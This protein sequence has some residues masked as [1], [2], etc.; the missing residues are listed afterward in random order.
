MARQKFWPVA[1]LIL[2]PALGCQGSIVGEGSHRSGPGKTTTPGEPDPD[3]TKD[4]TTDPTKDPAKTDPTKPIPDGTVITPETP[5]DPLAA[6]PSPLRRLTRREY[7]NTVRDLL[8]DTTH[9][10]DGFPVDHDDGFLF[11]RAGLVTAQDLSTMRDA[12]EALAA[13]AEKNVTMLAP[14]TGGV[15]EDACA[16]TFVNSFGLR[17]YRRP[18][19]RE[20]SDRLIALYRNARTSLGLT[21][22]GGIGLLVEAMLQSP[23][24]L[25]H[26]ENGSAPLAMDGNV[27]RLGPYENAARL[28]YFLWGSMPDAALF[29]A[30]AGNHLGT[31]AELEAQ[32][33]R[34]LADA[35]ARDTVAA[36]VNDW[37]NLDQVTDRPKDPGTYPGFTDPLKSAMIDESRAF[38]NSVVLDGDSRLTTLLTATN[39]YVNQPLASV[40][41]MKGVQGADLKPMMLDPAQRSGLL[42][43]A[44][45]LTVTGSTNGSH[46]V[47]RGHKVYQRVLCRELPPPPPTVPPAKPPS[48]GGTTRERFAEHGAMKCAIAC[49]GLMDPIGFAFEHYDGIGQ[50]RDIDNG[51]MVDSSGVVALDGVEKSFADARQLSELI[52]GSVTARQCMVT[53]WM[54]FAFDR[55]ETQGDIASLQ[56]AAAAFAK[57]GYSIRDLLVGVVTSRSFRFRAP[58]A[59]EM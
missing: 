37:L 32:A 3:P 29:D 19:A 58:N 17:A 46:P 54:R 24:F 43:R 15:A 6:G 40:Y 26:A 4:P 34:M 7:N 10:A 5:G 2:G 36:F 48:A 45:F 11:P 13:T 33:V 50:Y 38:V 52:A 57:N 28:S 53:Q 56:A 41:A 31:A 49:H 8:G 25:Y 16:T 59:G 47:K 35:R 23:A 22:A 39:S 14:C 30:A 27:V 12:A 20:E 9:P 51:K 1:L 21:Y 44:A 18:L 42:T 55:V